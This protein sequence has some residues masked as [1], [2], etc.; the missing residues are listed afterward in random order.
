MFT[1][2]KALRSFAMHDERQA[3]QF[4]GG[5]PGLRVS[6]PTDGLLR[7]PAG[8]AGDLPVG[9]APGN[10]AASFDAAVDGLAGCGV[11]SRRHDQPAT[12]ATGI[13][14]AEDVAWFTDP[15]GT[16]LP[17]SGCVEGCTR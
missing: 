17:V 12:G 9:R 14:R 8:A 4:H 6:E 10:A 15:V 2:T 3:G 13:D 16:I 1:N 7:L 5:T 11:G